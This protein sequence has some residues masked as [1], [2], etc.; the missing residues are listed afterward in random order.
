MD[1]CMY[2]MCG[3]YVFHEGVVTKTLGLKGE[4]HSLGHACE[5][6]TCTW[7]HCECRLDAPKDDFKNCEARDEQNRS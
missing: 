3:C 6:G 2:P 7:P 4:W 5:Q 1:K